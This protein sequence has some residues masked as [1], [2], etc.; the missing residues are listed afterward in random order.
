MRMTKYDMVVKIAIQTG[1]DQT[2]TKLVVQMALD[3]II[4]IL[5]RDGRFELRDFGVFEVLQRKQRTGRNPKTGAIVNVPSKRKVSF[6]AG[7]LL[8]QRTSTS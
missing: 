3:G 7:K 2:Q 1:V 8:T 4:D 5:I 6:R